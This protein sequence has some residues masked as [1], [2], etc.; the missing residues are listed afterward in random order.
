MQCFAC[1][2]AVELASGERVGFR[3]TCG[4][5]AADL[6]VCRNCA[7]HDPGAHNECREP[8]A[9]QVADRERSNRC[10]WFAPSET[11]R[12]VGP[13]PRAATRAALGG[14]FKKR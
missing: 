4:R 6:H 10:D 8:Q 9:E 11:A 3:D 2:Q 5:C 13:D 1:G 14:L 7:H 12:P